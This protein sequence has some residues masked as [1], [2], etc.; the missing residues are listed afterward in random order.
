VRRYREIM[1]EVLARHGFDPLLAVTSRSPRVLSATIPLLFDPADASEVARAKRCY[2]DLVESGLRQG[3]PPYRL[4]IDYM[5]LIGTQAGS[6]LGEL[7][8]RLKTALD[9]NNVISPGRYVGGVA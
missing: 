9:P 1:G 2:R 5:D 6:A 4:G 3:W 8:Q 7:H